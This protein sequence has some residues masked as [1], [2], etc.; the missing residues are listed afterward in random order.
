MTATNS[1]PTPLWPLLPDPSLAQQSPGEFTVLQPQW[2]TGPEREA[3]CC[4]VTQQGASPWGSHLVRALS[5]LT[6]LALVPSQRPLLL[7]PALPW[8]HLLLQWL[9]LFLGW[10]L[11]QTRRLAGGW[12]EHLWG[13]GKEEDEE[14]EEEEDV[15]MV[16]SPRL[17]SGQRLFMFVSCFLNC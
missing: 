2:E 16:F 9:L 12:L 8:L 17:A 6:S 7:S 4:Q 15:A 11:L 10:L 14:E 1:P 13:R 3:E 5:L